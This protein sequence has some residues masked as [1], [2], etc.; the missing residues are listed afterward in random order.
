[1][2]KKKIHYSVRGLFLLLKVFFFSLK[3]EKKKK[4]CDCSNKQNKCLKNVR[5]LAKIL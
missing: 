4:L 1:M 2:I 3:C 5:A